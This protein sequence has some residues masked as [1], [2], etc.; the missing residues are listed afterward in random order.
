MPSSSERERTGGVSERARGSAVQGWNAFFF[1]PADPT[2][3]GVIRLI[4]GLLLFWN[5]AV[6]GLDL[7][8]F[9]GSTGWADPAVV[10]LF[11]GERMPYA[12]S[13]WLS[14]PDAWLRPV[15]GL[16]LLVLLMFAAGL[17]SRVTAVLAWA[18]VVSTVR[19]VPVSVFGFDQIASTLAL[20]LAVSGA[21][22]QSVSLDHFIDRCA[23]GP[24][25]PHPAATRSARR[26]WN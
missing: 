13:F 10:R 6:Y 26:E 24:S 17:F 7:E 22:G 21:S 23:R 14:V 11:H 3:V 12:W 2:P 20:Y 15:W 25:D 9:L 16:C 19:R 1:N 8:G 5:L 18:I 4:V